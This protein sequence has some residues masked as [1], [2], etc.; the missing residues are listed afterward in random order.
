MYVA[1]KFHHK[2]R[3]R[4]RPQR[5]RRDSHIRIS[6]RLFMIGASVIAPTTVSSCLPT[7]IVRTGL[8]I[9]LLTLGQSPLTSVALGSSVSKAAQFRTPTT[10]RVTA[11]CL[12]L[13]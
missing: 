5:L 8:L 4:D 9:W 7:T 13:I 11:A 12:A 3:D 1:C 6:V 10:S 2:S